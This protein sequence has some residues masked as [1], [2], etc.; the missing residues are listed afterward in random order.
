MEQVVCRRVATVKFWDAYAKWYKLWMEHTLYHGRIIAVLLAMTKPDWKVLDIG[1][2]NGILSIP[3]YAHGCDVTALEPSIGMRNLLYGEAFKNRI[4][5]FN[6]DERICE[7]VP[8]YEFQDYDLIMACN[9]LHLAQIGFEEAIAKMFRAR[10]ANVLLV[11]EVNLPEIR[12]KWCYGDYTMV[13]KKYYE[14]D[15]SFA[16]H[17][18][19]EMIEHWT[20]KKGP[21]LQSK[22]M[23]ELKRRIVLEDR[24]LWIKDTAWVTMCWWSRN[25]RLTS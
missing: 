21:T 8:C 1:A 18:L 24:H 22:E 25:G 13:L 6:V 5:G 10:P 12:A 3:L 4:N 9:A 14:T 2:G 23:T 19:N 7:E 16:Y 20:F 17:H 15:S 11:S